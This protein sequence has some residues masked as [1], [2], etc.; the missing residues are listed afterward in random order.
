MSPRPRVS[1]SL[2][3]ARHMQSFC[4]SERS[5]R[6]A[7]SSAP[8]LQPCRR[9]R[10]GATPSEMA[11][12]A[13]LALSK[14]GFYLAGE[15]ATFI[16]TKFSNLIELPN[17]VQRIRREL[18][19][20]NIFIRKTGASYLSD[21]LLKA[22]ITEVRML[23]YRVEDI[24]DNFSYH[25]LQFKQDP[26]GKKVANG[27]NYGLV[28][29]G[30]A[31]DLA[32]IE[33]E[34][35]HVSKL[36]NMWVSSVHELLPNQVTSAEQ[37][38]PRYSLPQLVKDENLVG[39][40][41]DR[42]LLNKWLTP[43]VPV[44]ENIPALK[45]VSLLGMGGMGK[46]TL[47]TSVYEQLKDLFD[48]RAWL[49]VSQAYR[50]VDAL[51]KE[52]LK[53]VSASEHTATGDANN[54]NRNN[55]TVPVD[56]EIGGQ[57]QLKPDDIDKM[58]TIDLKKNLKAVLKH[59]KYIVVLDDVW[60]RRVH[61]GI[62]DVF[63]DSG[64]ESRIVITT[65]KQDV[66]SRATPGYLLKLNPLDIKD[67]LQLFC[68]K[69]FPNKN[70]FDWTSKL[71]EHAND[72][73]KRSEG[74][75]LEQCSPELQELATDIIKKCED[76][77]LLKCPS[78]LQDLAT[79]TVNKFKGLSL[80]VCPSELRDLATVI[81]KQCEDLPLV[82]CPSELQ[83]IATDI[84]KKCRG[85]PLAIVSVGNL[86]SSRK[87]IVPVWRQM[88]N[89]LPCELEKDDQVQGILNLS[90]YD[91]PS[92]LRNC[93][94]YCS[95]FPEDYHFS[96]DDLVRLWVAEGFVGRKGDSTPEEVAEGYLMELIHRNMLQLVDN[97]ELGRVSTCK[98]HDILRELALLISKAEM[99]GTVNDFGAMVQMD[100][101]V[102]RISSYGW[103]KMKKSK[104]K[105]KFPHLRTLMA[106]DT[107]V[108]YVPSIL[109][110]SKYLTVLELQN[111]DF[112][113]LPKSI[114]NLFNLKYIGLRNTR[115]T[116]LPESI[117]NLS[118][119][120]TLDVKSTEIK[121]LPP[122]IVNLTKLRHLT[123]DK[124][125]DENQSEFRYFIGVEAPNG[126]SNLEDLQTLETVQASKHLPE[127]LDKLLQL[128]SLW[129]D[130]ITASHCAELFGTLSTM[131]LLS[132]LL[133][134]AGDENETLSLKNF[135][136]TCTKLHK[137]IVRGCWALG[138]MDCPILQ[139]HGT[140]LKYLALSRCHFVEDPLV[141]LASCVPNLTYLRLNNIASPRTLVLLA[142]SF[143]HLKTLVFKDMNDVSLLKIIDGALPEIECL[144]ITS[145]PKLQT[146][147]QGIRTLGSLKK[148]WLLGLHRNFKAQW[149]M[150]GIQKDL[151]YILELRV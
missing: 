10:L 36:K 142:G 39:L 144:Y 26:K 106:S 85:L 151:Q 11:E 105:M 21:E 20:M 128:R 63:E 87:Q 48:I 145:L 75:P 8:P 86:L 81:V 125:V 68:T 93:F 32:K 24:M 121:A 97:D 134:S 115:I 40:K 59:K 119:L 71:L 124:F 140:Y 132:S 143:P 74:L 139:N 62:S 55:V 65:R 3:P 6:D 35:E 45:V 149:D 99:F 1:V 77:S 30:I 64:M 38:F 79:D 52:L 47:L 102:R 17:T 57:K 100:T 82:K 61:D 138:T 135:N 91:L 104:S 54:V 43:N 31:D 110:E 141:V 90:Y 50:G 107:I 94:L 126:L 34:I 56:I 96:K 109:S 131:P 70:H 112:R 69:A 12:A 18:L 7:T 15:A 118:N 16:A 117:E 148:L 5:G 29:S 78:E 73:I 49:T 114:G 133:I 123:A 80:S 76:F 67:A 58:D 137:L 14:I 46:T 22:W 9:S 13:L 66:A 4:R 146:V 89:E 147:P 136:P 23:A 19:M 122:G 95:L 108:D 150:D 42:E 44:V 98:L 103:K 120:Q 53:I 28:F 33:K 83:E 88:Y 113:E 129:I 84:V 51:L 37:Q 27:L 116:S 2:F 111:S 92:D 41:E 127:Q 72:I 25:S 60:D 130:N 101:G